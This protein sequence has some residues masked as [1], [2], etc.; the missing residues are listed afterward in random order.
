MTEAPSLAEGSAETRPAPPAD[1]ESFYLAHRVPLFRALVVV[2]RDVRAAED[3]TQDAFVRVWE[4]W[5]RVRG[6]DDPTGYL[7][8]TALNGWFQVRRRATRAAR[9]VTAPREVVDP[10]E[11]VEDRDVLA[12]RL[13][14]LPARQRAALL[15]TQYLGEGSAEAGLALGIR[16]GTVR[17]L[18]SKARATL[19]Q[20][21][22]E[23]EAPW[24]T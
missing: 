14:E 12:R 5:G 1:F 10:L 2:T 24:T 3:A 11:T 22:E 19:R 9:R 15:L 4:R 13:L 17:R 20:G 21:N 23:G 6:M 8:R 7:Y 18:A 16:P